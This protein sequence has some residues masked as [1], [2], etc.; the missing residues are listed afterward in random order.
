MTVDRVTVYDSNRLSA[1]R[2]GRRGGAWVTIENA[3]VYDASTVPLRR[4]HRQPEDL[5]QHGRRRRDE[6]LPGRGVPHRCRD[7]GAETAGAR[8]V[9]GRGGLALVEPGVSAS[10][11]PTPLVTI[12]R[13]RR[14][15]GD[16]RRAAAAAVTVDRSS[17]PR[18][19]GQGPESRVRTTMT[20][21]PAGALPAWATLLVLGPWCLVLGR[22]AEVPS[23]GSIL[24][25]S[26]AARSTAEG[27]IMAR[28]GIERWGRPL[29]R[30]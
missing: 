3:V 1:A 4:Q 27:G 14:I 2:G 16:R 22:Q 13:W 10:A 20:D 26:L 28:P 12:T 29:S 19:Q 18:P 5:E 30:R 24:A 17:V 9:A 8:L 21:R 7:G 25:N 6:P 11:L 15:A 23:T